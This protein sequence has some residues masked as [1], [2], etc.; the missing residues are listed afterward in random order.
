[1]SN[2]RYYDFNQDFLLPPSL[3]EWL[4]K[5]HL[6]YFVSEIIES[7]DLSDIVSSY[8]GK[9]AAGAP[10]MDPRLMLK[11]LVYGYCVGIRSSRKIERA[12]YEDVAFRVLATDQHPDHDTISTFRRRHIDALNQLYVQ[13][14][15]L[16]QE[17]GLVKLG[18]V[19]L[20]G[21]KVKAFANKSKSRTYV[22]LMKSKKE[23]E[24]MVEQILREAEEEDQREDKKYGKGKRGDE[25]PEDLQDPTK[26]LEKIKHFLKKIEAEAQDEKIRVEEETKRKKNEDRQWEEETGQKVPAR[27]PQ[28]PGV[29]KKPLITEARRNPTDFDSRIMKEQSSGGFI[30]AFNCQ[31]A[32]DKESQV[33]VAQ[34]VVNQVNDKQ[35]A[36]P[37]TEKIRQN[38]GKLPRRLAADKDYYSERDV[39]TLQNAGVSCYIP[40]TEKAEGKRRT[41]SGK[42]ITEQMRR[43]LDTG[44][45]KGFYGLR[46]TVVE[47]VFGQIK[48]RQRFRQFLL[49]GINKVA[50]EWALITLCHNLHKLH[51]ARRP[52]PVSSGNSMDRAI[53][54]SNG[55]VPF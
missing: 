27:Y 19:A 20:D 7:L 11:L 46:K 6:A 43:K 36:P 3:R 28:S 24:E 53:Y 45:G 40:P 42:T 32:V 2:F 15:R 30:Q 50:G 8:Q 21:T 29:G 48:E 18:Y 14:L 52:V 55:P 10:A 12:S 25:L 34:R 26:R 17:A 13:V 51:L 1:M 54:F 44:I 37:M 22:Q 16:C 35:L 38:V 5:G 41:D 33:I 4:P 23:L 9:T 47:P 39:A 49:R 31:A